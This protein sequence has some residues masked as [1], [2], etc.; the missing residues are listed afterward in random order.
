[1]FRIFIKSF[2]MRPHLLVCLFLC[3]H[4]IVSANKKIDTVLTDLDVIMQTRGEL[5]QIKQR[6]LDSIKGQLSL[7]D[8]TKP[9]IYYY[10]LTLSR[11]YQSFKFDSAL[12][13]T[14]KLIQIAKETG[15][16]EN[17][18]SAKTEFANILISTGLFNEAIDTLRSIDLKNL[19]HE[20]LGNYYVVLS[21]AYFDLESFSQSP[22]Y[23]EIFRERG[24]ASFD[25]ALYYLP[26][27]SWKYHSILAQKVLK[28]GNNE[29]AI[30]ILD[31]L[32]INTNLK[33]EDL[34]AL[35]MNLAFAYSISGD[36]D[37]ALM[38][39][40]LASISDFK[41]AKK[42][43]VALLFT[44]NYL[45]EQG[46]VIRASKYINVALDDSHFYGS[47]F[48]LWQISQ[49]LPVIKT[50]HIIT[51]EEQKKKLLYF[52]IIVS[53]LSVTVLGAIFIIFRQ[54]SVVRK[55]KNTVDET[56]KQLARINEEL[57]VTNKIKEEYIG[58]FFSVNSV[59]LE[60]L[61]KFKSSIN[62]KFKRKQYDEIAIELN[63]L[64]IPMEK[65]IMLENF[66]RVFLKIY[67]D[68]VSKFNKLMKEG[69]EIQLKEGQLLNTEL[70]IFALVRLGIHNPEKIAKILDYSLNTIYAYKN[71]IK[72]RSVIPNDEF[73]DEIMR[74]RH[75]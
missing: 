60:K 23:C 37:E 46:D 58:Y 21:R 34:G 65:E 13:Y 42:E 43:A 41:A 52:V 1:M 18:A 9:D 38:H 29:Q 75:F 33:D 57:A 5:H 56:N 54:F 67:P 27:N 11:E 15:S 8:E 45:F 72:T 28:L 35:Q 30:H 26:I 7:T 50:Q 66:D 59:L 20:L 63:S 73:E 25:S 22:F 44:A 14:N 32:I 49:F 64:S 68:F 16:S 69:E 19:K 12:F 39:M 53:I 24:M 6:N 55:A 31:S 3:I 70:R 62:R 10:Y 36:Q 47:S 2:E 51:I 40:I 17:I 4:V 71:R 74:I 48:R 61:D